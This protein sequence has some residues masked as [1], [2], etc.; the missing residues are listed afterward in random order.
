MERLTEHTP[1]GAALKLNSPSSDLEARE[2]LMAMYPI[3][4]NKLAAYE[5]TGLSPEQAH[6]L[7]TVY[8]LSLEEVPK[9]C[10]ACKHFVLCH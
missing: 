8:N 3:A 7:K 10:A 5:D 6:T 1:K 9:P 4:I 2:Q